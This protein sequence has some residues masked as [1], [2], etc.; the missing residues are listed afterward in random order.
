MG[1]TMIYRRYNSGVILVVFVIVL[2][3]TNAMAHVPYFE[4]NDFNEATPFE[5]RKSIDQSIAVYSWLENDGIN[6]SDDIDVYAFDISEPTRIYIELIVPA[7]PVYD[8][9]VPWFAFVGPDFPSS[10]YDFPFDI[11]QGYGVIVGENVEPGI[12]REKF[13]EPFGGKWYYEGP[14]F[15]ETIEQPGRYYVYYWDPY[16]NGGDY[17]AVLGYKEQFGLSDI[18][19]ALIYTPMIR[20]D[21]ELHVDCPQP[22]YITSL[23]CQ[24]VNLLLYHILSQS[25]SK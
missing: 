4:H 24:P 17:V 6:P 9:F 18:I 13:Y 23:Y 12:E 5:V 19:R 3:G 1:K 8:E 11:P 21:L 15:D 14:I 16:E 10:D 25:L 20:L 22:Q 7:C 2:L